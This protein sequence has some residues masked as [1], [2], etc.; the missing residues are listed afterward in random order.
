[1]ICALGS[2]EYDIVGGS[3]LLSCL[4]QVRV[5]D[6]FVSRESRECGDY[7]I[8]YSR[9]AVGRTDLMIYVPWADYLHVTCYKVG[10]RETVVAF[11]GE[12]VASTGSALQVTFNAKG[13]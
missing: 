11:N 8:G 1:M 7:S 2:T 13:S 12:N 4:C 5:D 10:L 6:L 3:T 9:P